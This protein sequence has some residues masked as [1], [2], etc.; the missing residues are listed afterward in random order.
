MFSFC[1]EYAMEVISKLVTGR[2]EP[3]QFH[4]DNSKILSETLNDNR[5]LLTNISWIIPP[6]GPLCY[7]IRMWK[8]YRNRKG[9]STL[10]ERIKTAVDERK[11]SQVTMVCIVLLVVCL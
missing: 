7:K 5:S 2:K 1:K 10:L 8:S 3:L 11:N 6:L 4:S 9:I